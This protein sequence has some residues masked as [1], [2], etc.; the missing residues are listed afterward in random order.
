MSNSLYLQLYA[1]NYLDFLE[2][3]HRICDTIRIGYWDD[4]NNQPIV[5]N[6][7]DDDA[8]AKRGKTIQELELLVQS[9]HANVLGTSYMG[10]S[11][12][13][14]CQTRMETMNTKY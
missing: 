5:E 4:A 14:L 2:K 11:N 13:R 9:R 12:C 10:Y 1:S 7:G 6:V 3:N 8:E